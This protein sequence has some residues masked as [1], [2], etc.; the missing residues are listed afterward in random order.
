MSYQVNGKKVFKSTKTTNKTLAKQIEAKAR[1]QTVLDITLGRKSQSITFGDALQGYLDSKKGT[2]YHK[3]LVSIV[4]P[5][6]G[7]K[8]CNK[9]KKMIRVQGIDF[10]MPLHLLKTAELNQLVEARKREGSAQNTIKQHLI[11]IGSTIKWAQSMG[12][13]VDPSTTVPKFKKQR[14]APVFL[15]DEEEKQLLAS[16]DPTRDEDGVGNYAT[17]SALTQRRLQDQWDFVVCLL[18]VGGRYH[19][20]TQLQWDDI[21]LNAGVMLVRQHKTNKVHTVYMT[22][23]VS[24]VLTRRSQA[25][26]HPTWVFTDDTQTTHRIYHNCWFNRAIKRAGIN[27]KI[28]H[29]NLR[30]TFASKLVIAGVS[31]FKVQELLGHSSPQQTMTYASLQPL[32]ASKEAASVLNAINKRRHQ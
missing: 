29:H 19:E 3:V 12:Y 16:I 5:L 23:R 1:E 20:I 22:D 7:Y 32:Q 28:T 14:T 8:R 13:M 27:K 10:D 15:T 4:N 26:N 2:P 31:L 24:Q 11:A 18:D 17:R 30:K 6:K 21:D 25:K 9:T